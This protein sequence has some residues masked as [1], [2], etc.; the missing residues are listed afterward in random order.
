MSD[1]DDFTLEKAN[2]EFRAANYVRAIELYE[3]IKREKPELSDTIDFNIH[4]AERYMNGKFGF[5]KALQAVDQLRIANQVLNS[6]LWDEEWYAAR[7]RKDIMSGPDSAAPLEYYIA[8]GW[9]KGHLPSPD[10]E[11][12]NSPYPEDLGVNHVSYFLDVLRFKG[13]H[14]KK[15][16]PSPNQKK[17]DSY[18][19][20]KSKR[21]SDK[22]IYTCLSGDYNDLVQPAYIDFDWDYVC[23]TDNVDVLRSGKH[24]GIWELRPIE[25]KAETPGRVNR[26]YKMHPHLLFPDHEKSIYIDGNINII[27]DYCFKVIFLSDEKILLPKHFCRTCIYDEIA[28]VKASQRFTGEEKEDFERQRQ[29]LS[30]EGYPEG[31]GL[32]ENNFIYRKHHDPV[33]KSMMNLWHWVLKNYSARDQ[34]GLGY[35]FW[36]YGIDLKSS[37]IENCRINYKNFRVFAHNDNKK[38]LGDNTEKLTPTVNGAVLVA[39]SC[40]DTFVPYLA[41][42]L[43]S[44]VKH[45]SEATSYDI[46]I[47]HS[48]LSE[49]NVVKLSSVETSN[50]SVRFYYMEGLISQIGNQIFPVDGYVPRETY[51]KCFLSEIFEGYKRC[52]YLDSDILIC[53][54]VADLYHHEMSG[55]SIAASRNVGN[56][57]AAFVNKEIKGFPFRDYVHN[58]LGVNEY[59]DYFQAGAVLID[60]EAVRKID[61]LGDSIKA[62]KAVGKPIFFDQCIFNKIFYKDVSFFSTAWNHVWYLQDYSYLKSS[63]PK[64]VFYDYAKGRLHPKIIHYASGDKYYNKP[65]WKL[66]DRFWKFVEAS[67]F[68]RDVLEDCKHRL[69]EQGLEKIKDYIAFEKW[70]KPKVLIHLH[71]YY[72]DQ[73]PYFM[74]KLDNVSGVDFDLYVTQVE[75]NPAD[76]KLIKRRFPNVKIL[77]IENSGYDIYPFLVVLKQNRLSQYDFVMKLH[78][79]NFRPAGQD[80]VYGVGV[81]GNTWR[82]RLVDAVLG[83]EEVF[84]SNISLLESDERIGCISDKDFIFRTSENNEERNYS[85]PYWRGRAH[86]AH[87]EEYVGGSMFIAKAYPF[88]KLIDVGVSVDNFRSDEF[89]TKDYKNL[90]HVFERLL[91]LV[92][93]SEKMRL[94][95]R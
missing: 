10:F 59:E 9:K 49:A 83:N 73:L 89:K 84:K 31:L 57:N 50:I 7:Y 68:E 85:L 33:V 91:G 79:K 67:R 80:E 11:I 81:P 51:N 54:D 45:S 92:V 78:T 35:C 74:D 5:S 75:R 72:R 63:L 39:F 93:G 40:N 3:K 21:Q 29:F 28:A 65:E 24:C 18:L 30:D 32:S 95:G 27:G 86:L 56:I 90:A 8:Y 13:Y 70:K 82:D 34:L 25:I 48:S 88:E 12:K 46:V 64:D 1:R 76:E 22:V 23:F 4:A 71:V 53:A 20:F 19:N 66:A 55:K 6:G 87:S 2:R 16:G 38:L 60:L 15:A 52:L 58:V 36:R 77:T 61:L 17:I 94:S 41:V 37:L 42:A 44:L 14:F 62:L 26:W 43:E 69:D 47:L